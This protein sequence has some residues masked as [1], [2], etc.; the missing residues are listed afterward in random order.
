[1]ENVSIAL[2]FLEREGITLVNID[3]TDIV[4]CK[5][6]LI[7]GLIWTLILHYA[8]SM[9]MWDGPPLGGGQAEKTPKQRLADWVKDKVPG[10][11]NFTSDWNDGKKIGQLVD[12][13]APGLCPDWEDWDP[14]K[15]VENAKEAM[16]MADKWL[17]VP[18]LLTPEEFVDPNVDEQ[19]M[20]TYL[21]QFPNAKLQPGAPLRKK[22]LPD[23]V[24]AFGPG[25]E[26]KG[27]VAKAPA[28]FTV[29]TFGAGDGEL[30]V[31]VIQVETKKELEC[32]I[33]FN[34]DRKATY[35]CSY[36]PEE[37]GDYVVD[38]TWSNRQIPNSPYNVNV[39]GFAGDASK[40]SASGPGLEA[41]GV[42]INRPTYFDIFAKGAGKG[43]PEVIILDPKGKKDSVPNR[44]T[45]HE[46]EPDTYKCEYVATMVGLHSVNVFFA[47]NPIPHSPFGVRVSPASIPS[48]V[49]AS[50]KKLFEFF[51]GKNLTCTLLY[52]IVPLVYL[53]VL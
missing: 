20:L 4:D 47:G 10:T 19:S 32:E 17:K 16:D 30:A 49:W 3:S 22:A 44:I 28:N 2:E 48:K 36:F 23:K 45:P 29:E 15:P 8:I 27:L 7:L 40:V 34:N 38:I 33:V 26:P 14:S 50:G 35:S 37:E 31:K 6:K 52:P 42:I 11:T 5:L 13:V 39:E 12:G 51:N 18:Q 53:S 24:R 25:L 46:S 21:S 41:E 1:M 9:P 43:S